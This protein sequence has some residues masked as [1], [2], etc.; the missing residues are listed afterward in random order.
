[1]REVIYLWYSSTSARQSI[2]YVPK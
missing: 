1:M 2:R